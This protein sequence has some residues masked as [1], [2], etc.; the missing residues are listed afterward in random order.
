MASVV[1]LRMCPTDL[2]LQKVKPTKGRVKSITMFM[3]RPDFPQT[4]SSQFLSTAGRLRQTN[5]WEKW[6]STGCLLWLKGS[7]GHAEPSSDHSLVRNTSTQ[8]CS[9]L[10]STQSLTYIMVWQLSQPSQLPSHFLSQMFAFIKPLHF[11][12]HL[13][14]CFSEDPE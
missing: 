12:F 7:D 11:S 6:G 1:T 14:V 8:P 9:P 13:G 2:Q 4:P 10:S 3:L 5:S